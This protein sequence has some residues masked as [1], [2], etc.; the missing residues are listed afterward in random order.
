M[1]QHRMHAEGSFARKRICITNNISFRHLLVR[2]GV[3][4]TDFVLDKRLTG[5]KRIRKER[6]RMIDPIFILLFWFSFLPLSEGFPTTLQSEALCFS[7][8]CYTVHLGKTSFTKAQKACGDNGGDLV[9]VKNKEE[10]DHLHNLLLKLPNSLDDGPLKLWIGL[11]LKKSCYVGHKMLKGFSWV[12]GDQDTEESQF[13]NWMHEPR[14]T[15][16]S[17]R[18]VSMTLHRTSPDNLKWSDGTCTS[19]SDGYLCKF[20]FT[21]MCRRVVLAGPGVVEYITPFDLKSS[22]LALVPYGSIAM[23]SCEHLR[24]LPA[25]SLLCREGVDGVFDWYHTGQ[26]SSGPM[27]ASPALGC[28]YNNGGCEQDCIQDPEGGSIHCDCKGGY[29]L[30]S[31][32]F[33]CVLS[34]KCQPSPC[35]YNCINHLHS[36]ECS[37][38]L[39]FM[40]AENQLN[41]TDVDEC[42]KTPCNQSCT[43]TMGSFQCSCRMGFKVQDTQCIDLDECI[44]S[45][46][47]QGCLNTHGSYHCSCNEGYVKGSDGFSCLDVD[48]CSSAPCE[49]FCHNTIGSY[50]CSCPNGFLLS[51]DGISCGP[52][53]PYQNTFN[54]GITQGL[55]PKDGTTISNIYGDNT[56]HPTQSSVSTDYLADSS[57]VG[58]LKEN[59]VQLMPTTPM[60]PETDNSPGSVD[61]IKSDTTNGQR[62]LLLV[63]TLCACSVMVLL[64]AA[65]G[66]LYY[67]RRN[68]DN[69]NDKPPSAADKYCWVPDE[70]ENRAINNDNR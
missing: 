45:P 30:A 67:R 5:S 37:C 51:S 9:T 41:C 47:S 21:G 54:N 44:G 27:C 52:D 59:N 61:H 34:S 22:S 42:I 68:S 2:Y 64:A 10:A 25:P 8:A 17:N 50:T 49:E 12:S 70:S 32:L 53:L 6:S 13:S 39:G 57:A 23:V 55:K 46:C 4:R 66:I 29:M 40:L 60:A 14:S 58:K 35:Q 43:N 28:K 33:S 26:S 20:L 69:E 56:Y 65:A 63:C 11:Q 3:K 48:E 24:E 62:M 18:C 16:T 1:R 36:F 7:K 38:P 19:P 31:D 15:C